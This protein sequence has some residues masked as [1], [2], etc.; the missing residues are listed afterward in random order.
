MH[1]RIFAVSG[2]PLQHGPCGFGAGEAI[3]SLPYPLES[4]MWKLCFHPVFSFPCGAGTPSQSGEQGLMAR[5]GPSHRARSKLFREILSRARVGHATENDIAWIHQNC[6]GGI[7]AEV[8]VDEEW[9]CSE[10]VL[11]MSRKAVDVENALHVGRLPGPAVIST[12]GNSRFTSLATT[13][14]EKKRYKNWLSYIAPAELSLKPGLMF[15]LTRSVQVKAAVVEGGRESGV[16]EYPSRSQWEALR[17]WRVGGVSNGS[18]RVTARRVDTLPP[19][20]AGAFEQ[21]TFCPL[22][23]S[24]YCGREK[25]ASCVQFPFRINHA[26]T[27]ASTIGR[28]ITRPVFIDFLR[29]PPH[30]VS[31]GMAYT[32]LSRFE[33]V[34]DARIVNLTRDHFK[35]SPVALDYWNSLKSF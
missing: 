16:Q 28:T 14:Y 3:V 33:V 27:F 31:F 20:S 24:V 32:I 7:Q 13:D 15:E 5:L 34:S 19:I 35:V 25:A 9:R 18:I 1:A 29:S 12:A 10:Q 2:D 26:A 21:A 11:F 17:V 8:D 6:R 22:E 4:A 30:T 23:S